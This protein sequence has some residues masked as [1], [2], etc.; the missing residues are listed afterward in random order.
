MDKFEQ[1]SDKTELSKIIK[2]RRK[3][4]KITQKNLAVFCN[5]SVNGISQIEVGASDIKLST[6]LKVSKI[7]GFKILFETEE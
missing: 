5:L 6:L 1:I 3:E 2:K 4:L 7:L